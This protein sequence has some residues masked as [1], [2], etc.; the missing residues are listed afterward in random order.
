MIGCLSINLFAQ[1]EIKKEEFP[2]YQGI[3]TVEGKT[4]ADLY[5]ACKLWVAESFRD[6]GEVTQLADDATATLVVKGIGSV[7]GLPYR[8][9]LKLESK[10]N[11][12]R[13]TIE[14]LDFLD[15]KYQTFYW[16]FGT[17]YFDYVLKNPTKKRPL[18]VKER[19]K[20]SINTMMNSLYSSFNK[21][22]IEE[23]W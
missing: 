4:Q 13:Y 9:S 2:V 10:E 15:L 11:R 21:S 5:S 22:V 7:D 6:A 18:E 3:V 19:M 16:S 20:K 23:E 17:S 14:V 1:V 8:F 12:C